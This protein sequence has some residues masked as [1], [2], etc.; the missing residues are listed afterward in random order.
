MSH[1]RWMLY[2]VALLLLLL[3]GVALV[4]GALNGR[5]P[6]IAGSGAPEADT[7][8]VLWTG[9][10]PPID[11]AAA[12]EAARLKVQTWAADAVLVRAEASWRPTGEWITTESPPVSWT[13]Y[14]YAPSQQAV[15]TVSVRGE[16]FFDIPATD[17]PAP[18]RSLAAFP[19]TATVESAWL[20]FRAAGGE[21]FLKTHENAMVQLQLRPTAEVD[22][23][24]VSAFDPT[25]T[26]QV[27]ID[28]V[29]GLMLNP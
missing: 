12:E 25:A 7:Q 17:V 15:K 24:V 6:Q 20:T 21:D 28:A 13:Y 1:E 14:Y 26:L 16:Q 10:A 2:A 22:R 19:P 11:M 29:T 4:W 9:L 3:V 23:W 5:L 27:T 18:P 8:P